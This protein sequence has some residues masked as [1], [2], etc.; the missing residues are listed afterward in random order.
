MAV[1]TWLP[2]PNDPETDIYGPPRRKRGF[3][4]EIL[5]RGGTLPGVEEVAIG[6][7]AAIPL[8]HG[9][10]DLNPCRSFSKTATRQATSFRWWR[11]D[12]YAGIFSFAGHAADA[13]PFVQRVRQ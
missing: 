13:R 10:N 11:I 3:L 1:R 8:G 4:R 5:R 2:V 12:G 7:M 9:R 6:D